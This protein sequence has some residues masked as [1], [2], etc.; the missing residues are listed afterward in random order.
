LVHN[1]AAGLTIIPTAWQVQDPGIL[2]V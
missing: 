2:A 1:A